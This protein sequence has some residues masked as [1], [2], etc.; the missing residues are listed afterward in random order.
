[1]NENQTGQVTQ[2][3]AE[4]YEEF[5]VPALFEEWAERV[6]DAAQ[7]EEG[8]HVLDVA[9]GTGVLAREGVGPKG[10][11]GWTSMRMGLPG[12]TYHP[13]EAWTRRIPSFDNGSLTRL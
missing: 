4:T 5:F 7:I 11:L 9:C 12:G 1:M 3:A 8:Q 6:V 13:M 10:L 2:N